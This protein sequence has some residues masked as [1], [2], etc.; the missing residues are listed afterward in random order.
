M[1]VAATRYHHEAKPR[2]ETR[3]GQRPATERSSDISS[4]LKIKVYRREPAKGLANSNHFV[5]HLSVRKHYEVEE[6]FCGVGIIA[7]EHRR[8]NNQNLKGT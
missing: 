5:I 1:K 4:I 6:S 3:I 7:A 8:N 2:R